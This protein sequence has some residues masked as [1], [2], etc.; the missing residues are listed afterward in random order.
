MSTVVGCRWL[1][2][3]EEEEAEKWAEVGICRMARLLSDSNL[4]GSSAD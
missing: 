4:L 1:L 2:M 3:E